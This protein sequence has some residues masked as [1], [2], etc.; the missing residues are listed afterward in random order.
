M[1]T[2]KPK[3]QIPTAPA[4]RHADACTNTILTPAAGTRR[5][6]RLRQDVSDAGILDHDYRYYALLIGIVA[7][8]IA[9]SLYYV[10]HVP[11]SLPLIFWMLVFSCFAVQA[12]GLIH[13]AGHRTIFASTSWNNLLGEVFSVFLGMGFTSWR[14]THNVHHAHT[15]MDGED[16]DLQIPLHAFTA[17][18][19]QRQGRIARGLRRYQATVFYPM[20]TLVV[21]SRR[22]ASIDH[23][24]HRQLGP[25]LVCEIALWVAGLV[26]WFILPFIMFPMTKAVLF[27]FIVHPTM[28]FYLSNV[29]APNHKGMPQF[30]KGLKISF[31][32]Q[33]IRTSRNV[34][35]NWFID[36]VFMGLN[37]QIEHH[38]F[39]TCPRGKLNQITPY[40]RAV[41]RETGLPYT[42]VGVIEANRLILRALRSGI[43]PMP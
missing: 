2:R 3:A 36:I 42:E 38:L 35:P 26:A 6:A 18:Q 31:L 39:P 14:L 23:L 4:S 30:Q 16:P 15:N 10:I 22:L 13:D 8:G 11:V 24:R 34:A 1:S 20:R 43:E 29:F 17:Q 27:F 37:Y 33:Q 40:V 5:Y 21:F 28:G 41:C 7:S 32:E 9:I 25:R 19:I 12:C